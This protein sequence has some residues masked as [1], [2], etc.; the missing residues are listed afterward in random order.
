MEEITKLTQKKVSHSDLLQCLKEDLALSDDTD[1]EDD[2]EDRYVEILKDNSVPREPVSRKKYDE[3]T[4]AVLLRAPAKPS[5]DDA[6]PAKRICSAPASKVEPT[7][8]RSLPDSSSVRSQLSKPK[9]SSIKYNK[10]PTSKKIKEEEKS[11][12]GGYKIP[13]HVGL[14]DREKRLQREMPRVVRETDQRKRVTELKKK[15]KAV[16][17]STPAVQSTRPE[18]GKLKRSQ[19]SGEELAE[20]EDKAWQEK[21]TGLST[22]E[23]RK[24]FASDKFGNSVTS[25]PTRCLDFHGSAELLASSREE[26]KEKTKT[27]FITKGKFVPVTK[28]SELEAKTKKVKISKLEPT[29]RRTMKSIFVQGHSNSD[30]QEQLRLYVGHVKKGL[31]EQTNFL[32][33][34]APNQVCSSYVLPRFPLFYLFPF[35]E[36]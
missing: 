4:E 21:N 11:P 16:Y 18:E 14:S 27:H 35:S 23:E 33:F 30:K 9:L 29:V 6:S 24:Q 3:R 20:T 26:I 22:D 5:P 10:T 15:F 8:R 19:I 32:R 31:E 12:L 2:D 13:K 28:E 34:Y 36:N 7:K 17:N 1:M 25:D